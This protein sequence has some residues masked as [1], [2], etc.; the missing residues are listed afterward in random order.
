MKVSKLVR[1]S[2]VCRVICEDDATEQDIM[3]LAIPK[4]S[5][6]LMDNPFQHIDEI[7]DDLEC[8]FIQE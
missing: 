7:V 3:E 5:E 2:M 1:I 6:D 4:L 8:P